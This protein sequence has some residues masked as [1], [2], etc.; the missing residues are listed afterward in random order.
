MKI[1]EACL[2]ILEQISTLV[3]EI[4]QDDFIKPSESLSKATIGQHIRH[5]IEFFICLEQGYSSGLINYD[6][7]EHN[8]LIECDKYFALAAIQKSAEFIKTLGTNSTLQLEVGYDLSKDEYVSIET[9]T[10]RELVYN[11]E[12]AVH[13]MAIIKIGV[14]EVASYLRIPA[15]FGVAASTVRYKETPASHALSNTGA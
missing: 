15:N 8:K 2:Q 7:R 1:Q 14:R 11:V 13:H 10:L 4:N 3:Q 12:H 9:N 5:T 6:K